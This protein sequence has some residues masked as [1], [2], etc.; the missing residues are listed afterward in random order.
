MVLNNWVETLGPSVPAELI[1]KFEAVA[2]YE[3]KERE[4]KLFTLA[5]KAIVS[6]LKKD[7]IEFKNLHKVT[8][9]ITKDGEF[10]LSISD[11]NTLGIRVCL[12]V[13]AVERWRKLN[14]NDNQILLVILEELCHHYWN[15]ENETIVKYKV[16]NI[17]KNIFPGT[18][19]EQFYTI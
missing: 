15:I 14:F 1:G 4:A 7:K 12:A 13:Y 5:L 18:T 16:Y 11:K 19:F 17:I 8:A 10:T 2:S 6:E 9:I 3:L